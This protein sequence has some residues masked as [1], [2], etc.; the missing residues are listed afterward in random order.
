MRATETNEYETGNPTSCNF[1]TMRKPRFT[2]TTI[3]LE[4][5]SEGIDKLWSKTESGLLS[6]RD[7]LLSN[8]VNIKD[9]P[10]IIYTF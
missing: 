8:T 6:S 1:R 9:Q 4:H 7:I 5:Q 2:G 3:T 10:L